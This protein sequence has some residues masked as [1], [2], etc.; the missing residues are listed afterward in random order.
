MKAMIEIMREAQRVTVSEG[1]DRGSWAVEAKGRRTI[2]KVTTHP[3]SDGGDL[4]V[5]KDAAIEDAPIK[6]E[7]LAIIIPFSISNHLLRLQGGNY[8][9]KTS[10]LITDIAQGREHKG[11]EE[12]RTLSSSGNEGVGVALCSFDRCNQVRIVGIGLPNPILKG[13]DSDIERCQPKGLASLVQTPVMVL[14]PMDR[15]VGTNVCAGLV[16]LV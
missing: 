5:G 4:Q 9:C 10:G 1:Q 11:R 8:P 6:F 14:R 7:P 12:T 15:A 2:A 13:T 3:P 16:G